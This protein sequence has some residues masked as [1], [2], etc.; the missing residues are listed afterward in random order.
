VHHVLSARLSALAGPEGAG[1]VFAHPITDQLKG[2]T[3]L[4]LVVNGD[5]DE[6][7]LEPG[8][9]LKRTIPAAGLLVVPNSGHTLNLEEPDL[10][11]DVIRTF[12]RDARGG[13]WPVRDPRSL[14]AG[15]GIARPAPSGH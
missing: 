5:E 6:A 12:I 9:L 14:A 3:A 11:N 8:L 1:T 4:T 2:I 10:Y 13:R 15:M 7:C